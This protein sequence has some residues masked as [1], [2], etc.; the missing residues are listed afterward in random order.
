MKAKASTYSPRRNPARQKGVAL[1]VILM[2]LAIM[3]TISA[4]MSERLFTQFQRATN[5]INYQQA[6]WYSMGVEALA[7]VGIEQ[8]FE[9]SDTINLNQP[10]AIEEQIYPLDYGEV[11]GRIYDRQACFN[12]NVLGSVQVEAGGSSRPYLVQYWQRLLEALEVESYQA[13]VIADSTWEFIDSNTTIQSLAGVEDSQYEAMTP[14][15]VAANSWLADSS[16][17]RAIYQVSAEVMELV[18]PYVC[19]LPV[20]DWRMNINTISE[21]HPELLTALFHPHLSENDAQSMLSSRPFDGWSNVEDFL[22]EAEIAKVEATVRDEARK[23]LTVDSAYFEMDAQV[24]V[25]NS[26]MR[27]RS[28]LFS[29]NRETATVVRRRFGGISGRVSDRSTD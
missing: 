9:D 8:S 27:V 11:V 1:I 10:W 6:Y 12:L 21:E 18:E 13:E 15:Y 2:I 25:E 4:T 16:E 3:T 14:P 19:A 7:Q 22:A 26:R 20:D 23:Y 29:D 24:L 17:L 28:L 5:Q